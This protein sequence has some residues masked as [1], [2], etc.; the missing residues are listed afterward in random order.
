VALV[1]EP[2]TDYKHIL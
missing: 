1:E 2:I